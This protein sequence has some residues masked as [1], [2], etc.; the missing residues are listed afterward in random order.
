MAESSSG[1]SGSHVRVGHYKIGKTIGKGNFAVVKIAKN[2]FTNS[3]VNSVSV[4]L[5]LL[6]YTDAAD[7]YQGKCGPQCLTPQ[8][9]FFTS[10]LQRCCGKDKP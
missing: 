5:Y 10:V 9:Q 3:E 4:L 6:M 1:G 2:V 7:V 8:Y